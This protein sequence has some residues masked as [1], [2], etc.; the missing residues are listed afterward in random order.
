MDNPF[1]AVPSSAAGNPFDDP[2]PAGGN[3]FGAAPNDAAAADPTWYY[4]LDGSS[5]TAVPVDALGNPELQSMHPEA[6]VWTEGLSEWEPV[7]SFAQ[8]YPSDSAS[9]A[10][11][12]AD[13]VQPANGSVGTTTAPA[14][15]HIAATKPQPAS[16][17]SGEQPTPP[18]AA[19]QADAAVAVLAPAPPPPPPPQEPEQQ[20][21]QPQPSPPPPPPPQEPEPSPHAAQAKLDAK[22][23]QVL[24]E[25]IDTER[26]YIAGLDALLSAYRPALQ[27]L[28]PTVLRPLFA[29]VEGIHLAS[30]E[31][32]GKVE[33]ILEGVVLGGGGE[34]AAA[35]AVD[36][37]GG[38][39]PSGRARSHTPGWSEDK[40]LWMPSP[41]HLPW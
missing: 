1:A 13:S 39:S 7:S 21:P 2:P 3:P 38:N 5:P 33:Y 23:S 11:Q 25:L 36:G 20:L 10:A 28:A 27:P 22:F 12:A 9:A 30:E 6:L 29:S 40:M 34:A 19:P 15:A 16:A 24:L 4:T 8:Y 18:S 37:G 14:S 41:S 31:L 32:L 26:T 17:A 35:A